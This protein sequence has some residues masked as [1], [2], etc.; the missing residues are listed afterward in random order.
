[1]LTE[2][3]HLECGQRGGIKRISRRSPSVSSVRKSHRIKGE[4]SGGGKSLK[5]RAVL[6]REE[7]TGAYQRVWSLPPT[8]KSRAQ[9]SQGA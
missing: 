9:E 5:G 4:A 3:G 2:K 8:P 1:M 6:K 7:N